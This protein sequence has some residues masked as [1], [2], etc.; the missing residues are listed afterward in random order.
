MTSK[1]IEL[2]N[3]FVEKL[4]V[5]IFFSFNPNRVMRING[6]Y[7]PAICWVGCKN[8]ARASGCAIN[9]HPLSLGAQ[10]ENIL[11]FSQFK[12]FEMY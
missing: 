10:T 5:D 2:R 7:F 12:E 3:I 11:P 4:I 1:Y 9:M 6:G 8:W